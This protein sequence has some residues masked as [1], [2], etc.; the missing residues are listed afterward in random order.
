[1]A[2]GGFPR[3][4]KSRGA[5]CRDLNFFKSGAADQKLGMQVLC[6]RISAYEMYFER[7]VQIMVL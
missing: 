5:V 7:V 3:E 1:M 4:E 6:D 2:R